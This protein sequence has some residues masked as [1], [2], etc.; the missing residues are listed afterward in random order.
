MVIHFNET[1]KFSTNY[2]LVSVSIR[3]LNHL[4]KI[5]KS[6]RVTQMNKQVDPK[7]ITL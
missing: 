5:T 6:G 7:M 2:L 1:P 4:Q 3:V